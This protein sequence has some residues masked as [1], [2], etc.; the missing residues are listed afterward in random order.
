MK[1]PILFDKVSKA[2][3]YLLVV[4]LP[5]WFLPLT[6]NMVGYQKQ[7]LLLVLVFVGVIAWLAK[8]V[9]GGEIVFRSSWLHIPAAAFVVAVGMATAFSLW[10][11]GSFW[12]LPLHVADNFLAFGAF[13]LLYFLVSQTVQDAKHLFSLFAGFVVSSVVAVVFSVLQ[14]KGIFL[15]PFDFARTQ[16]FHVL[17]TS[18]GAAL[19][20]ASLLPLALAF[21]QAA[22]KVWKAVLWGSALLLFA[23]LAL[24]DFSTAWFVMIAGLLVLVAFDAWNMRQSSRAGGISLAMVFVLIAL[25]FLIVGEFSIPGAPPRLGEISPS[26]SGELAILRG[27][28][29]DNPLRAA[30]GS[31]PGTFV[32][33]YAKFHARDV[34]QDVFWNLRFTSGTSEVLDFLATKGVLGLGALGS[35]V[36]FGMLF[37]GRR[38]VRATS[39]DPFFSKLA[40]G[41]LASFAAVSAAFVLSAANF[42]LWALFWVVAGGIG[43][44]VARR[45]RVFSLAA[46]PSLAQAGASFLL[47]ALFVFGTGVLIMGGQKYYAEV[48]YFKGARALQQGNTKE[49]LRLIQNAA[50]IN[51]SMDLYWRDLAQLYLAR[52]NEL[53]QDQAFS[54]DERSRQVGIAVNDAIAS[55]RRASEAAGHNVA[56]WNVRGFVYRSLIG[57]RDAERY[58]REAYEKARELEPA[59]PFAWTEL[60]RV[61]ILA[62][63]ATGDEALYD[64]ALMNL[65]RAVELKQDY[66]PAHY[67][68]AV[69][70]DQQGNTSEAI[71]KLE[72]TK[73]VAPNDIGLAFQLGVA[74]YRQN[75][76]G[77]AR[78]EFER[79]KSL[80][81]N[82]SNA[83]YMLGLT[84]DR[85]GRR[86]DALA[87]FQAVSALNPEN[88]EVKSI[89]RNLQ[90]GRPALD[91]IT[92]A[93]PPIPES[94]PEVEE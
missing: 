92:P 33:D 71:A 89:L 30:V 75:E 73:L 7:V 25:F 2:S 27:M 12:G 76:F 51:G 82:Y 34:N 17:G 55:A 80:N 29:A 70:H 72:E 60:G 3:L 42:S 67:L 16:A 47:L 39:Q 1:S 44:L 93:Q 91:G 31:G 26:F 37:A 79:A 53:A 94:P 8:M 35:F 78:D 32:F 63:Q 69:A 85:L 14:M 28:V 68:I 81:T 10:R 57:V 74:Y 20:A 9:Y 46:G 4:L 54:Q 13:V 45:P 43:A 65:R 48:L 90:A 19:F 40:T 87:E 21:A 64:E 62:A 36:G 23:A 58:A 83:R 88:E 24:F 6:Q 86:E 59:S 50:N 52:A 56:N 77:K 84:Y 49:A 18:N 41:L 22:H 15:I 61:A 38:L 5:V 11:Y 66:A